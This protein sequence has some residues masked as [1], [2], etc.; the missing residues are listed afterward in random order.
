MNRGGLLKQ[1]GTMHSERRIYMLQRKPSAIGA[2]LGKTTG[3]IHRAMLNNA[4]V[5][6]LSGVNYDKVDDQGLHITHQGAVRTLGVDHVIIC[7]G[8]DSN[9]AL[10]D[11]LKSSG[12]LLHVIG[13]ADKARELDAERAIR[14]GMQLA[15]VI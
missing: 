6:M 9:R 7:A 10:A 14:Q 13:G 11:E 1:G 2:S 3:W 15:A 4:G 5:E 8:Q 12:I